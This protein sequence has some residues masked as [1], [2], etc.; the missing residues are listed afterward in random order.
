MEGGVVEHCKRVLSGVPLYVKPSLRFIPFKYTPLYYYISAGFMKIF[1]VGFLAPRLLSFLASLSCFSL[2]FLLVKKETGKQLPSFLSAALFAATFEICGK[3]FELARVDS[4]FLVF[5][6]GG[7]YSLRRLKGKLGPILCGVILS[8]SFFTKQTALIISIFIALYYLL[9][10]RRYFFIFSSVFFGIVLVFSVVL[11][12]RSGGWFF[13][14]NF[15][16]PSQLLIVKSKIISFWTHNILGALPI[17]FLVSLLFFVQGDD[18]RKIYGFLAIG[19]II[20][21]WVSYLPPGGYVNCLMP[22]YAILSICF[23]L[24]IDRMLSIA[25][26]KWRVF[27]YWG[28]IV[29]FLMLYNPFIALDLKS[30]GEL[31]L[32]EEIKKYEGEV[33]MPHSGNIAMYAGKRTFADHIAIHDILEAKKLQYKG[34]DLKEE[35]RKEITGAISGQE[36]PTIVLYDCPFFN[37]DFMREINEHYIEKWSEGEAVIYIPKDER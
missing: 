4:L 37:K 25:S 13:F 8:L 30:S 7:I 29:Q 32:V 31:A 34:S 10:N 2:I 27:I 20:G 14:Y 3:W 33:L 23:G 9:T 6:L 22:V 28:C 11:N 15:L 36:F 17:A 26:N 5:L 24:G 21:A 1:G 35:L 18:N 19:A 12:A 16:L